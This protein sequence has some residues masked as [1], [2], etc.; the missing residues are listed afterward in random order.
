MLRLVEEQEHQFLH[1][2]S[3]F[4]HLNLYRCLPNGEWWRWLSSGPAGEMEFPS[5][6]FCWIEDASPC[7]C[8]MHI[9]SIFQTLGL[10]ELKKK[11]KKTTWRALHPEKHQ[12][13]PE[14]APVHV[15]LWWC[16]ICYS[17]QNEWR[18]I[19]TL[20]KLSHTRSC[21]CSRHETWRF[22]CFTLLA[23]APMMH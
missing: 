3:M 8:D 1:V 17:W 2:P 15:L 12:S 5:E 6:Q 9:N 20:S 21:F 19:L 11:K 14:H 18:D 7:A 10:R 23:D 22:W 16:H 13:G 4:K